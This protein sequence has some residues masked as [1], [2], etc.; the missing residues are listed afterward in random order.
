MRGM[1]TALKG[2]V[3]TLGLPPW[4]IGFVFL[5]ALFFIFSQLKKGV[6]A[7]RG[8]GLIVRAAVAEVKERPAMEQQALQIVWDDGGGLIA[9]AQECIRRE[10]RGTAEKA[11]ARLEELGAFPE[12][13]RALADQLKGRAGL[14]LGVELVAIRNMIDNGLHDMARAR[15]DRALGA[16]PQEEALAELAAQLPAEPTAETQV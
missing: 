6:P 9:V 7:A 11:I 15:L 4:V 3:N 16:W 14:S 12:K 2:L 5:L 8:R 10:R 1:G 13:A